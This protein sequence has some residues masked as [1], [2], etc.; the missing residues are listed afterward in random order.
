MPG[1]LESSRAFLL[2]YTA[3]Y[4]LVSILVPPVYRVPPL[5]EART[6]MTIVCVPAVDIVAGTCS[7]AMPFEAVTDC[8]P[9]SDPSMYTFPNMVLP[10]SYSQVA[11]T[12]TSAFA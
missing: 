12:S 8:G 5:P 10:G 1:A 9:V 4:T 6:Y 3:S 2:C 7:E 11:N